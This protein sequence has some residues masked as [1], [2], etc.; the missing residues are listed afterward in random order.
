MRKETN[1]MI[2]IINPTIDL[3]LYDLRN[4]FGDDKKDIDQRRQYFYQ[5]LH[6]NVQEQLKQDGKDNH[7]KHNLEVEYI[8]LLKEETAS[9]EPNTPQENGYYY[10]VRLGDSYGLLLEVATSE[11]KT[12]EY[13]AELKQK[14]KQKLGE[15]K[16]TLGKTWMLSTYLPNFS[17]TTPE[18]IKEIAEECYK[19]IFPNTNKI[20][21]NR[22]GKFIGATIFE[23]SDNNLK[24]EIVKLGDKETVNCIQTQ[25]I[26]IAIY[27]DQETFQKL[28]ELYRDW[29]RLLYYHHKIIWAYGQSRILT[30][31]IKEKFREIQTITES[32]E[33]NI[34]QGNIK[35]NK[36]QKISKVLSKIQVIINKYASELN[37]LKLQK[38]TI[39]INLSNYDKR[40]STFAEKAKNKVVNHETNISFLEKFSKLVKEKYFLQIEKDL[41][42]FELGLRLLEDNINAIRSQTEIEKTQ[43]DRNFQELI[44]VVGTGIAVAGLTGD[45]AAAE[46]KSMFGPKFFL[47]QNTLAYHLI[48]VLTASVLTWLFRKYI[49]KRS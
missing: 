41:E 30:N 32:I 38:G 14:I 16:A 20:E 44:A 28:G 23:Y 40:L 25:H 11:E 12:P 45:N 43:S 5:K 36:L 8:P 37:I 4:G 29:M 46:C 13:F 7:Q 26:I 21:F 15:N 18:K 27:P 34:T 22:Q 6:E 33:E 49:L 3:F 17:E 42:S 9:L 1:E 10:P 19:A 24:Q 39:T 47:C 35:A 48:L 31:Q 2:N